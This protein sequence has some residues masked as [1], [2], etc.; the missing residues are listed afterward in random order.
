[1]VILGYEPQPEVGAGVRWNP[2]AIA[3]RRNVIT[4]K[5]SMKFDQPGSCY[6]ARYN[7]HNRWLLLLY[8]GMRCNQVELSNPLTDLGNREL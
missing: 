7:I 4:R 5:K 1:M 3:P 8:D 2:A 6:T